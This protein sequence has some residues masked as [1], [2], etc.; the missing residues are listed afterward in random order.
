MEYDGVHDDMKELMESNV[1][2]ELIPWALTAKREVVQSLKRYQIERQELI[3]ELV[4][5]ERT[6]LQK[7]NLMKYMYKIPLQRQSV[8]TPQQLEQLF[9]SL[10]ELILFHGG[11]CADLKERIS[12][13][14]DGVVK[15][16]ADVLLLRFDG[17]AGQ[18]LCH[19]C[20]VFA[21][22]QI[23]AERLF[24]EWKA[25][26]DKFR[27]FV[28]KAENSYLSHRLTFNELIPIAWQRL[29]KYKL[30]IEQMNKTYKKHTEEL[31]AFDKEEAEKLSTAITCVQGILHYVNKQV[32]R[33]G[34]RQRLAA[35]QTKLDTSALERTSHPIAQL[36][37]TLDLTAEDRVLLYEGAL[38]IRLYNKKT[39]ELYA[40]LLTDIIV[41]MERRN[42]D[43]D[44][45]YLRCHMLESI[46]GGT[47]VELSPIIRLRESLLRHSAA[48][49][50]NRTFFVVNNSPAMKLA[51]MYQFIA[52][53]PHEKK[54][55]E[56]AITDAMSRAATGGRVSPPEHLPS[57]DLPA[58]MSAGFSNIHSHMD[59]REQLNKIDEDMK[60]LLTE[61]IVILR[62][63]QG[64]VHIP[65]EPY[66][67][68]DTK[69]SNTPK[70]IMVTALEQ[71]GEITD[72]VS[73][74]M[75]PN[76]TKSII[77]ETQTRLKD[78]I[79]ELEKTLSR[80]MVSLGEQPIQH[81]LPRVPETLESTSDT[82]S[83]ALKDQYSLLETFAERNSRA[84]MPE[85]LELTGV[86]GNLPL[87]PMT[88]SATD[89][90]SPSKED[91]VSA[92]LFSDHT[93][94]HNWQEKNS[95]ATSEEPFSFD[96]Q[97][98]LDEGHGSFN[99]SM[100]Q[101]QIVTPPDS[102]SGES[103]FVPAPTPHSAE[104]EEA[105]PDLLRTPV[106]SPTQSGFSNPFVSLLEQQ[107]GK[108][109]KSATADEES[110]ET[111]MT[112]SVLPL[113][114]TYQV[115]GSSIKTAQ[116]PGLI[117]NSQLT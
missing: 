71:V 34:N 72:T 64:G 111:F 27:N 102:F 45:Y 77:A 114:R 56:E 48:D 109:A 96:I 3:K 43:K 26:N 87:S 17:A 4:Y 59:L 101:V 116:Q 68:R 32:R 104:T 84:L 31:D 105:N 46:H 19:A 106:P 52:E 78:T 94:E 16:V 53:G 41:L 107:I 80:L 103:P 108:P 2:D 6:H 18:R 8:L 86:R 7:L 81:R 95:T 22:N 5:T 69:P 15:S 35:Y 98:P 10:E 25:K 85:E 97:M 91:D 117:V 37:K 49:R 90:E 76:P 113:V 42:D 61:K 9:P 44:K 28:L 73:R 54:Q 13:F 88:L 79:S 74:I 66:R 38:T 60:K 89:P 30:L 82:S 99:V 83:A 40:L 24:K 33:A 29:T 70:D 115:S 65:L 21:S 110:N 92:P 1:E 47:R 112:E 39:I 14:P 50:G 62:A 12:M 75:V 20:S 67:Q 11:L 100:M 51:Q 23:N 93:S 55:W 63:M 58:N 57:D 36:Y